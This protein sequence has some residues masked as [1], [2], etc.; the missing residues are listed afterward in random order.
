MIRYIVGITVIL[1]VVYVYRNY[2]RKGYEGFR[3][4][5]P[6]RNMSYDLR[7]EAYYPSRILT[8]YMYSTIGPND[9]RE[10]IFRK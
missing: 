4:N 7:G 1:L 5:C 10:C 9:P 8:P 3:V 6:T 2:L